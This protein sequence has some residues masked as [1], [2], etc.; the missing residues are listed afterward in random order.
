MS[1]VPRNKLLGLQVYNPDGT[2]LGTVQDIVLP[3]DQGSS[4]SLSILTRSQQLQQVDW[5]KVSA[6]GDIVI[7]REKIEVQ[8]TPTLQPQPG[9]GSASYPQTVSGAAQSQ[10]TAPQQSQQSGGQ[11]LLGKVGGVFGKKDQPKCSYC[12]GPLTYISQY[13]RWYCYKCGKYN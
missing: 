7:L 9:I 3:L 12:G 4:I 6:V 10:P 11:S 5:S 8:N 2:L 1:G 13:N